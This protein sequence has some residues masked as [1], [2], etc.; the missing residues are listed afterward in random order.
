MSELT[1]QELT[2]R[3]EKL[4][5]ELYSAAERLNLKEMDYN[6]AKAGYEDDW[7]REYQKQKAIKANDKPTMKD[8]ETHV[9]EKLFE[10]NLKLIVLESEAVSLRNKVKEKEMESRHLQSIVKLR[11][12]EMEV[13]LYQPRKARHE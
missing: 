2:E 11:C 7:A 5:Y 9:T 6:T 8:L 3:L 12:T 13:Q 10:K 4:P 1:N